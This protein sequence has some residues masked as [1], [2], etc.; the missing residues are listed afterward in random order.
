MLVS[1]FVYGTKKNVPDYMVKAGVTYRFVTDL[2]SSVR[3][4]V[5]AS[6]GAIAQRID[7]DAYGRVLSDS[8]PGF[9]PFGYAGGLYDSQ[10]Q[11]VKF[12]RRDYDAETGRWTVRDPLLF[13]GNDHNLYGYVQ[14]NP[15]TFTDPNGLGPQSE[16]DFWNSVAERARNGDARAKHEV[17]CSSTGRP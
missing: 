14:R 3:L 9:Q 17:E 4:V 6:T 16:R 13:R 2:Q 11:L 10:T 7:Y 15:M 12:G 8:N 5:N 1:R